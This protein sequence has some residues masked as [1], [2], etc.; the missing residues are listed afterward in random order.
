LQLFYLDDKTKQW[1][2]ANALKY[3]LKTKKATAHISHFSHYGEFATAL[4]AGPGRIMASQVD[5]Q[6]GAFTFT[7]PIEL[8]PGPGG[9]QPKL[10]LNYNSGLVDE[11]KN[12]QSVGS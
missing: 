9:F 3:D 4:S 8:P 5:L 11:M 2:P 10:A 1:L 7:Y 6:S 12:K